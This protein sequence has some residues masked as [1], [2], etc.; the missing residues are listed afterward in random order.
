MGGQTM[1]QNT[2]LKQL[3]TVILIALLS[4]CAL[5]APYSQS[6]M[7]NYAKWKNHQKQLKRITHFTVSGSLAYF[8]TKTRSYARFYLNQQSPKRYELILST[9]LGTSIMT[10]RVTNQMATLKLDDGRIYTRNNV[11]ALL[12]DATG[13]PI[14]LTSLHFWLIGF[15]NTPNY[16][17]LTQEGY[18]KQ[19]RLTHTDGDW[20]V[21]IMGYHKDMSPPLPEKIELMHR[22]DRIRLT[23]KTWTL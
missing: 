7:Q 14:P 3:I 13:I 23:L 10:L 16:D 22:T 21:T 18:L 19:T 20:R 2:I 6:E 9:P 4:A 15:S 8:S 17:V 12:Q 1:Q 5:Q 11:N